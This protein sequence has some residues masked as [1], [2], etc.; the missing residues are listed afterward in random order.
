MMRQKGD[1]DQARGR[2][3]RMVFD[4]G[5][6]GRALDATRGRKH[7]L[8]F[9]EGFET[10]FLSGHMADGDRSNA[11]SQPLATSTVDTATPQGANDAAA[12]GEIWRI[13]SDARF[14]STTT[15]ERMLE[16]LAQFNRSDAVL[17]AVDIGGLRSDSD[18]AVAAGGGKAGGG[19][20][21]LF[22]MA[23][24][25]DGDLVRNANDLSGELQKIEART[26]LVYLLLYQPRRLSK[27]G[28][29]H[30]LKVKARVPGAR[31]V[32]RSGYYEPRPYRSLSNL[33]RV[34]AAGDLMTGGSRQ[35]EIPASLLAVPFASPGGAPQVSVVLEIP[36]RELLEGDPSYARTSAQVYVYA[37][38]ASGALADYVASEMTLE[39][40]K[41]RDA[42]EAG[43][44]KLF[45]TLTLAPGDYAVR[46]LVRNGTTGRAAMVVSSVS[47]PEIPGAAPVLLPPLFE[48]T[49][50][51][52][53]VV[54]GN[55]R[56]DAPGGTPEFPFAIGGDSFLP[57]VRTVLDGG[58]PVPVALVAY[59]FGPARA[60]PAPLDVRAEVV[61]PD[62]A[63]RP[64]DVAVSDRSDIEQ[65]GG[66]KL[67]LR[68]NPRGLSPGAYRLRVA[69]TD[70]ASRRTAESSRAFEI[71]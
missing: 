38:D 63:S 48:E 69:V 19:T 22:A 33:E 30:A 18:A 35:N 57:S 27:P 40:A 14:G 9:S 66:R 6:I 59:N 58:A 12:S 10:R 42:L 68:F 37:N 8:F 16:A 67:V 28:A 25:T 11:L 36:G 34:L 51:R 7:V 61:A 21:A 49:P 64:A 62:G 39:L 43:G 1:D 45:G 60:A 56:P 4:L 70:P 55:P 26:S 32:A 13:D 17:D 20:D 53:L 71:H 65:G 31:V 52:W 50:G 15:R 44:L 24:A 3:A 23:S 47:V 54:R 5:A 41:V 2:V 46:A 29:F